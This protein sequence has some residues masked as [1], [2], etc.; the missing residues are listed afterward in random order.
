MALSPDESAND[1][2]LIERLKRGD[3]DAFEPLI[4]R[5][6]P[7][8]RMYV[9][10]K[11]PEPELVAE[12]TRDAFV[13]AFQNFSD[14][15][16]G[17]S[18]RAWLRAI[19]WQLIGT[20]IARRSAAQT[21]PSP[22]ALRRLARMNRETASPYDSREVDFFRECLQQI[23]PR[24]MEILK[25]KYCAGRDDKEIARQSQRSDAWV[26]SVLFRVRQRLHHCITE[27]MGRRIHVE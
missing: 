21:D 18:F 25:Q 14:F 9:A 5:H 24:F 12:I 19:A 16:D 13:L 6:L 7:H 17:A 1:D 10:L 3:V 8:V 20:E 2:A 15:S 23:P 27:K 26:R 22:F 11:A 4:E